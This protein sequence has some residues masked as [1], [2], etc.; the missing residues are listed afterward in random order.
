M[1]SFSQYDLKYSLYNFGN[2]ACTKQL[3]SVESVKNLNE[4]EV[5]IKG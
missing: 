4:Y 5:T 3:Y 2:K 1:A